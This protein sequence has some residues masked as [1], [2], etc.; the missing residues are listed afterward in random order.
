[1][2][3]GALE[4]V[5]VEEVAGD[6]VLPQPPSGGKPATLKIRSNSIF[7]GRRLFT[8][9]QSK[10]AS[11]DPENNGVILWRRVAVVVEVLTVSVE[12]SA[13]DE[14]AVRGEK[15]HDAPEGNPEQLNETLKPF[16]GVTETVAVP[17]C[18]A[19]IVRDAGEIPMEKSGGGRLMV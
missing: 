8:P 19:V 11:S 3:V 15:L 5:P 9:K 7:K 10:T 14:V 4:V 18:P 17:L 12:A 13:P 6:V 2:P 16:A 1:V